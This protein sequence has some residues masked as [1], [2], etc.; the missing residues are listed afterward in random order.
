[1]SNINTLL[2]LIL[3]IAIAIS[4]GLIIH[5]D[6]THGKVV[7]QS[8]ETMNAYMKNLTVTQYDSLG[9]IQ[10][11]LTTSQMKQYANNNTIYFVKPHLLIYTDKKIPWEIDADQ[12]TSM[13]GNEVIKLSGNVKLHQLSKNH[14]QETTVLTRELTYYPKTSFA[15]TDQA[16]T[17]Q[18]AGSLVKGTGA[19]ADLKKGIIKF[20]SSSRGVYAGQS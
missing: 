6:P 1:M 17:I 13:N 2:S 10:S 11:Y 7:A 5:S 15:E 19:K 14:N 16:V 3:L 4:T 18:Q 9:H 20:L 8:S 12:G